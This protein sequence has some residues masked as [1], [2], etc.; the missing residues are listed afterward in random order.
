MILASA[1]PCLEFLPT[2]D[3]KKE[4]LKSGTSFR[5]SPEKNT[6]HYQWNLLGPDE[7]EMYGTNAQKAWE[8]SSGSYLNDV[9]DILAK[10]AS[11][12]L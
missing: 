12:S 1:L 2:K 9:G 6:E 10:I 5:R 8:I 11:W 3:L 4:T 7:K